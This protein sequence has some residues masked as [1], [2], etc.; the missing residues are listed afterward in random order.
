[1]DLELFRVLTQRFDRLENAFNTLQ[2][3]VNVLQSCIEQ[4]FPEFSK[5]LD[6]LYSEK[7]RDYVKSR[8]SFPVKTPD[9]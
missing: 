7:L 5:E 9:A 8:E 3:Q 1:M 4:N 2:I 6:A